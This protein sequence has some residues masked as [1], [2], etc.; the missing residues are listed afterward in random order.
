MYMKK[1][2]LIDTFKVI[3]SI[4]Y[5]ILRKN[6][7]TT[8]DISFFPIEIL[9]IWKIRTRARVKGEISTESNFRSFRK[10][11]FLWTAFG[12]SIWEF[13]CSL[14]FTSLISGAEPSSAR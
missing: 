8:A 9:A 2:V 11:S 4:Q 3:P 5:A 12:F 1:E 6:F 10:S 13:A 7:S 14:S